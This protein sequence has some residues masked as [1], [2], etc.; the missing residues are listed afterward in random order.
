MSKAIYAYAWDLAETGPAAARDAFLELG[1]DTITLAGTYH[2]GK[3]LR[4]HGQAGKVYFPEDGTAYFR[5]DPALYGE[6]R[7]LPNR[8][9]AERD[10]LREVT[11]LDGISA[12]VWLVLL[13]NTPLGMA[14]PDSIVRNAFGDG[15]V[16]NLCPSAPKAR[17][18]ARGLATDISRNYNVTGLSLETPGFMPYAHGYHHEFALMRSNVWLENHLGLCFCD[19][20]IAGAEARGIDARGLKAR[21][22]ADLS[23]YLDSE[24]DFA[25]DMAEAFW[26]ADLI[27]NGALR[28][29]LDF[30]ND[31]V[32]SLVTEI[33]AAIRPELTLSVIPSVARP[34]AGAWYEGTDL[35]ALTKAGIAIEACFYEPSPGRVAADLFDLKRR[36]APNGQLRGILRPSYPDLAT[37]G[38]FIA[39]VEALNAGHVTDLAFYNYGH[40]RRA[41]LSWIGDALRGLK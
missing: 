1:L 6:I 2:A 41:N 26:R 7:P 33:R 16:Y 10:L 30:R 12:S 11:E 36:I 19:H 14:H 3:F 15:Y 8:L 35:F 40:L 4:P 5:A 22:A 31:V 32:T 38:E 39:A 9:T 18:Y 13:H 37:K 17:A 27:E 29:Y 34:T 28:A 23:A 20:C 25:P 21:V 24:I